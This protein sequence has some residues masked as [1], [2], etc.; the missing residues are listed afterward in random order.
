MPRRKTHEE[1]IQEVFEL[2]GN[3]YKISSDTK[4]ENSQKHIKMKHMKCGREW[5]ITPNNFLRGKGCPD[6]KG[7]KISKS[8]TKSHD[9]FIIEF[10]KISKGEYSV[11]NEY[12][13]ANTHIRIKHNLCNTI[14]LVRPSKFLSGRKCPACAIQKRTDAQ[15]HSLDDFINKV[16]VE[17]NGEYEVCENE[18]LRSYGEHI[19]IKHN[20]CGLEWNIT[21]N[22]FQQG[23]RCPRCSKIQQSKN[24]TKTHEKFLEEVKQLVGH[25][26]V[27]LSKYKSD[28][29]YVRMKHKKCGYIYLVKPSAF[30]QNRR[31]P[32]CKESRGRRSITDFLE[33]EG[34]SY[35]IEYEFPS[36]KHKRTL[37]FD[38]FIKDHGILIEYDGEGHF[39]P[40]R[41]SKDE[42]K[43]IKKLE[44]TQYRDQIKN[45]YC[46]KHNIPL[47]RIPYWEYKNIDEILHQVL[48]YF[49]ILSEKRYIDEELVHKYLVNHS[50]WSYENYLPEAPSNRIGATDFPL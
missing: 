40:F 17:T 38:V 31:C 37:P 22:K 29:E 36:C 9:E 11:M 20:L 18:V 39:E 15:K 42:E 16:L 13:M 6:C 47:I 2:V 32:K 12:Q 48:K 45:D 46:I 33:K 50:Q 43:M 3:E 27:V 7:I 4:Y 44:E 49:N 30:L 10:N 28:G 23:R 14:Y 35:R 1:F 34:I 24:Q 41:Y 26:Y 8:K 19:K 5:E 21:P 25:D